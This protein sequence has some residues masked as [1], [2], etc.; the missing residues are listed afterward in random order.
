[1]LAGVFERCMK[2]RGVK[3]TDPYDW[4]KIPSESSATSPHL[5][6]NPP[7][8]SVTKPSG[9]LLTTEN[10][11]ENIMA[12]LDNNQENI[13][14]N[15]NKHVVEDGRGDFDPRRRRRREQYMLDSVG[16]SGVQSGTLPVPST[17]NNQNESTAGNK[18]KVCHNNNTGESPKRKKKEEQTPTKIDQEQEGKR[19]PGGK[20]ERLE[21]GIEVDGDNVMQ[22]N[23]SGRRT[24]DAK[25]VVAPKP[26]QGYRGPNKNLVRLKLTSQQDD[27]EAE[28]VPNPDLVSP[29]VKEVT[30][31][32][33]SCGYDYAKGRDGIS[34]QSS[35][36]PEPKEVDSGAGTPNKEGA[37]TPVVS[38]TGGNPT[39][40]QLSRRAHGHGHGLSRSRSG[41]GAR[42]FSHPHAHHH[43]K[44]GD[45]SITQFAEIDDG[46]VS[47]LQQITR[48]GGGLTLASQ[49]KS[50]FDDSEE[51]DNEWKGAEPLQSPEHKIISM[52]QVFLYRLIN[53]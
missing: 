37:G 38:I 24:P 50:Q 18:E 53:A 39:A 35:V 45:Y 40:P 25:P 20:E 16:G 31:T 44:S 7:L 23:L 49:W 26:S 12:S 21:S 5:T 33:D 27:T 8:A 17:V 1:M 30:E 14:P 41:R 46:N 47:A 29:R 11:D 6:S 10:A 2:R 3:E 32:V 9:R 15:D 22:V 42:P 52:S 43:G 36:D 48:G 19:D 13:E 28:E 51:T 34:I 4:E